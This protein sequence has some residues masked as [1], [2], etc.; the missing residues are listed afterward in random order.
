MIF[1]LIFFKNTNFSLIYV[2]KFI[3]KTHNRIESLPVEGSVNVID[4][5]LNSSPIQEEIKEPVEKVQEQIHSDPSFQQKEEI[6]EDQIVPE[7]EEP[8]DYEEESTVEGN[9]A[10]EV[11]VEQDFKRKTWNFEHF[12]SDENR[13]GFKFMI[14]FSLK[15]S[16]EKP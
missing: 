12:G 4:D 7:A 9:T 8:A 11:A 15:C 14:F 10:T 16:T 5:M 3:P 6:Q 1:S 2:F 13:R